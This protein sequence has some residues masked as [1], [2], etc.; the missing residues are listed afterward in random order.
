M[1][2]EGSRASHS[3]CYT[4]AISLSAGPAL[5]P[6]CWIWKNFKGLSEAGH[7]CWLSW[8]HEAQNQRVHATELLWG[9]WVSALTSHLGFAWSPM[10][11]YHK[12]AFHSQG[13]GPDSDLNQNYYL[14]DKEI[15][16]SPC[17]CFILMR[18]NIHRTLTNTWRIRERPLRL[19]VAMLTNHT[20][21]TKLRQ[22][23]SC[24]WS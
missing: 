9:W 12:N 18:S 11:I 17:L 23:I 7:T 24:L 21:C 20:T 1:K 10:A 8:A 2:H 19:S 3:R 6:S 14:C 4:P 22:N 5:F 16:K 15:N 13:T